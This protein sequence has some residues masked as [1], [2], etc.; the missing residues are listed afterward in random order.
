MSEIPSFER[1]D[2]I[3]RTN[4]HI[5]RKLI[6]DVLHSALKKLEL[7]YWYLG[8][9]SMWFGDFR[10]AHKLLAVQDMLSIEH[11]EYAARANFNKPFSS[12]TVAAGECGEILVDIPAEKWNKPVIAWLDYDK[13]LSPERVSDLDLLLA[14]AAP[15]SVVVATFNGARGTYR[16]RKP[17]GAVT[18]EETAV[19][20]VES[21]LGRASTPARFEPVLN[22][23]GVPQDAKE[24]D[25]PEFLA[26]AL[27]T[28]MQHKVAR[29]AREAAGEAL[30]FV[31]LY[32]L[33]HKDG[34]DM[35]TV[36]GALA[37]ESQASI[38]KSCVSDHPILAD[39][40]GN[41]TYCK[42]DVIPVTLK[43]KISLDMC[44]PIPEEAEGFIA[45]AKELGLKLSD[46][47]MRKYKR[48]HRHFPLF[49]ETSI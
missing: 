37:L 11:T 22:A 3:L 33:C 29:E 24:I 42:M 34:A 39:S 20:V 30:V 41:A 16:V 36:G 25:F 32:L 28:Y 35:V 4:K 14:N 46:D 40:D 10:L 44:L 31:P 6:F 2:Y 47:E 48:F 1:F 15:N 9:G 49:I 21:F 17:G 19:G 8:F 23:A 38:W 26:V 43:E 18:R 7:Q 45:L 13:E 27:I 12:V 5:E